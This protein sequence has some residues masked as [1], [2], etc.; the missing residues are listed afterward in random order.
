MGDDPVVGCVGEVRVRI[1]GG[2]LP[3]EIAVRVGGV[4]ETL[5]AYAD[6]ALDRGATVLVV[7]TRG[8][9]AVDVIPWIE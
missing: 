3:G 4:P 6:T 8:N 5:I 7:R 1:R 2:E 9:R